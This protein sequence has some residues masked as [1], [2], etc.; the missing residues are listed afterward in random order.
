MR[1]STLPR[2]A[3]ALLAAATV[4]A[5]LIGLVPDPAR[6]GV[7]TYR[8][9][10]YDHDGTRGVFLRN[11]A[12]ASN[13]TSKELLYG[14]E[15]NLLCYVPNGSPEGPNNTMWDEVAVAS[16]PYNGSIGYVSE[17]WLDTPVKA[18]Q[19]VGGE[20]ACSA[21]APVP[22]PAPASSTARNAIVWAG[23]QLGSRVWGGACLGFVRNAYAHAGVNLKNEVSVPWGS[24][25]Y[26]QDIWGHFR[27]GKTGNGTPPAGALVFY[28]SKSGHSKKYS[29]IALASDNAGDTISTSDSVSRSS[30]HRESIS[31]HGSSGAYNRY[32]GWWLP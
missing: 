23:G 29:H 12:V 25:T 11:S 18:N 3:G 9:T 17:H 1:F 22:S 21:S 5:A 19:H 14:T 30:V 24:G 16:G 26:P 6:A 15:V 27:R 7:M 13:K 2:N 20:S 32:V 28:L 8:I 31:Q 4:A 10:N